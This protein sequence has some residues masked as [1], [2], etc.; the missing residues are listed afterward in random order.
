MFVRQL[1]LS[2]NL[3]VLKTSGKFDNLFFL[4]EKS[5]ENPDNVSD[6]MSWLKGEGHQGQSLTPN[7]MFLLVSIS[8]C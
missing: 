5:F 3:F 7:L 4:F 8:Q 6:E 1:K 2:L